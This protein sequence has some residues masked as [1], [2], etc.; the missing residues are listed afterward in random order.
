MTTNR[1]D[2]ELLRFVQTY[3]NAKAE[4][5]GATPKGVDWRDEHSHQLRHAILT[6]LLPERNEE[7]SINDFGCGYGSYYE[8]LIECGRKVTYHGADLAPEMIERA[9]HR[10][11]ANPATHFYTKTD[12]LPCSD[13]TV[14][15]GIFNVRGTFSVD[16]WEAHVERT[17]DQL[18]AISRHG[19]GFNI[20][21]SYS[22]ADKQRP[23]LYYAD[24]CRYFDLCARRYSRHVAIFQDYGLY[25]F[26]LIVRF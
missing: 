6:K 15:S 1:G 3:Y 20:L 7:H 25:E 9:R 24:P 5:Y 10:H 16:R 17:L 14:A 2:D 12:D 23:D 8:Y 11:G 19:F 13:F 21:S 22:D 26:T 4:A 18:R